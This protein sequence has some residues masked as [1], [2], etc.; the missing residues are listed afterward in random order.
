[1]TSLGR[2]FC[3]S[4][5]SRYSLAWETVLWSVQSFFFGICCM[6]SHQEPPSFRWG[7]MVRACICRIGPTDGEK[8][9]CIVYE[10]RPILAT[11]EQ[12][13]ALVVSCTSAPNCSNA[14]FWG[15]LDIF[16][17]VNFHMFTFSFL[18]NCVQ[19]ESPCIKQAFPVIFG[20]P[21]NQIFIC[22]YK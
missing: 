10:I 19:H 11:L 5:R 8:T 17:S 20:L 4:Q 22:W 16:P 14:L 13:L 1:M 9:V 6:A 18:L 2:T 21:S 12:R 7:W 15:I 3:L